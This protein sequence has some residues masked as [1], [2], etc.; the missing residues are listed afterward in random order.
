MRHPNLG[1][2]GTAL[3]PLGDHGN[4]TM[5]AGANASA[6]LGAKNSDWWGTGPSNSSSPIG[7]AL[8]RVV[9]VLDGNMEPETAVALAVGVPI[10]VCILIGLCIC[11]DALYRR[12]KA[13][14]F[15]RLLT[16]GMLEPRPKR[17]LSP[18]VAL[19]THQDELAD[20]DSVDEGVDSRSPPGSEAD[21][22]AG[23]ADA[24]L[25]D[26]EAPTAEEVHAAKVAAAM[27]TCVLNAVHSEA[28]AGTNADAEGSPT[29]RRAG[30]MA[31]TKW[32]EQTGLRTPNGKARVKAGNKVGFK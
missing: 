9:A 4:A 10:A 30:S 28:D 5:P 12:A 11:G 29:Q 16:C 32:T 25:G 7:D 18:D 23:G 21:A 20:V 6:E 19:E 8:K 15:K 17:G 31:K 14:G 27:E 3:R 2:N 13:A 1:G 24:A 22:D 26:A